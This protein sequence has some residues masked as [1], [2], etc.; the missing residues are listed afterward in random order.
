MDESMIIEECSQKGID[1]DT[2]VSEIFAGRNFREFREEGRIPGIFI[3]E[4]YR[5]YV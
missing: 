4:N 2:V 1:D 3:R 5:W